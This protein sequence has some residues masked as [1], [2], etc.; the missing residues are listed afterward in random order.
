MFPVLRALGKQVD[1]VLLGLCGWVEVCPFHLANSP[2][3]F[4]RSYM[5]SGH[6]SG[7]IRFQYATYWICK[8]IT[9]CMLL[10]L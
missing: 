2:E 9:N 4:G 3:C 7:W 10:K 6:V 8:A 1:K 5:G